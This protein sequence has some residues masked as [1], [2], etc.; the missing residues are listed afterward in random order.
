MQSLDIGT[1]V[2][3]CLGEGGEPVRV[4]SVLTL[5]IPDVLFPATPKKAAGPPEEVNIESLVIFTDIG[6]PVFPL[7]GV[8]QTYQV[9]TMKGQAFL[10]RAA[11]G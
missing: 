3:V 2:S 9:M 8:Q 5:L 11:N 10:D 4:A 7:P 6:T 1:L